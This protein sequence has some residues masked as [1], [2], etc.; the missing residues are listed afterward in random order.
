MTVTLT[1][2]EIKKLVSEPKPLPDNYQNLIRLK[3]KL[4]HKEAE[5]VVVGNEGSQFRIIIRQSVLDPL[6]FTVILAYQLL[7]SNRIIRLRRYNGKSHEHKNSLENE[8]FYDFHIHEATQR[9]QEKGSREDEFAR[10]TNR[11]VDL[12][13]AMDCMVNDCAFELPPNI[14]PKLRF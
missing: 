1:D 11:Y 9:Y 2:E 5:F 10:P 14:P 3:P 13:G 6:D 8:V 4:G 7:E 12:E